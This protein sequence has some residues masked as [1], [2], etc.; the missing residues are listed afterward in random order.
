M[1]ISISIC[2][3]SLQFD[4]GDTYDEQKLLAAI[5]SYIEKEAPGATIS[6]LQIGHRQGDQWAKVDG[7]RDKGEH[8]LSGFFE[9]HSGDED[10]FVSKLC[11]STG[12]LAGNLDIEDTS[13]ANELA[14]SLES[15]IE[16]HWPDASVQVPW[17][18]GQ[19]TVPFGLRTYVTDNTPANFSQT[20]AEVDE[21]VERFFELRT[22]GIRLSAETLCELSGLSLE[23]WGLDEDTKVIVFPDRINATTTAGLGIP[24]IAAG[25]ESLEKKVWQAALKE[26]SK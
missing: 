13:E 17:Q 18:H 26:T 11:I 4:N 23:E 20:E 5:R 24:D 14:I 21:V 8:L 3:A 2:P 25:N 7:N 10:L 15:F 12:F 16:Q 22:T 1:N 9:R 19:G 6:C